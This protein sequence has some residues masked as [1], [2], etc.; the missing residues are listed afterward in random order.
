MNQLKL[1][2]EEPAGGHP[3]LAHVLASWPGDEFEWLMTTGPQEAQPGVYGVK[4]MRGLLPGNNDVD[5]RVLVDRGTGGWGGPVLLEN[6]APQVPELGPVMQLRAAGH[7][8]TT[9]SG[10]FGQEPSGR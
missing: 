8:A 2:F 5:P 3:L 7:R 10:R 9:I 4:V 6:A 1:V